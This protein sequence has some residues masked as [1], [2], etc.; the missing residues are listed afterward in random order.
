MKQIRYVAGGLL[1][2]TGALL[3]LQLFMKQFSLGVAI[4]VLFGVAY[5]MTGVLVLAAPRRIWYITGI[6]VSLFGILIAMLGM[7]SAA[8][9]WL[10]LFYVVASVVAV[11]LCINL[12]ISKQ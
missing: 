4:S 2:A 10:L 9:T 7:L 12:I 8:V 11:V 6:V 3:L 1:V 5:L